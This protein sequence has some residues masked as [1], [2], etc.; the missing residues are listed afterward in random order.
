[1]YFLVIVSPKPLDAASLNFA[2]AWVTQCR[3][4][5]A[6]FHVSLTQ[7]QGQIMYFLVNAS[8]DQLQTLQVHM[9]HDKEG[10]GQRFVWP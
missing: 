5:W 1:M 8:P 3:W 2:G 6:T 7:G 10:T 9:S 4:D